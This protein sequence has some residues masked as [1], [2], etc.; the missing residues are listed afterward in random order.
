MKLPML[1]NGRTVW[2]DV[3]LPGRRKQHVIQQEPPYGVVM[4]YRTN[5]PMFEFSNG[6]LSASFEK[7]EMWRENGQWAG[8]YISVVTSGL[9]SWT[10]RYVVQKDAYGNWHVLRKFGVRGRRRF[11]GMRHA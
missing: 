6:I 3:A 7:V 2:G 4:L 9:E 5:L 1:V 8:F 11:M 10:E